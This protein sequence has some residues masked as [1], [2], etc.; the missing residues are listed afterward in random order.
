MTTIQ[1]EWEKER[2]A[3]M[4]ENDKLS[5]QLKEMRQHFQSQSRAIAAVSEILQGV[6]EKYSQ[7]DM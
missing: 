3:Y 1:E 7:E 5:K 6:V 2:R 4:G